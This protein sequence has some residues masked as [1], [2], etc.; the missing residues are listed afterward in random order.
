MPP[1]LRMYLLQNAIAVDRCANA[2]TG[3][4]ADETLSSR[5]H[6]AR[7]D[8][9]WPGVLL[10]PV[11]D[12]IFRRLAGHVN[13]CQNAWWNELLRLHPVA[14]NDTAGMP[15]DQTIRKGLPDATAVHR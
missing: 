9:R 13:H 1:A 8:G 2:F 15:L 10:C 12:W 6:R 5:A 11:I 3:G 14:L 4:S 7:R